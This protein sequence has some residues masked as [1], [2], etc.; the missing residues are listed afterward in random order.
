MQNVKNVKLKYCFILENFIIIPFHCK[1]AFKKRAAHAYTIAILVPLIIPQYAYLSSIKSSLDYN[2]IKL[3]SPV[4]N[5]LGE[6]TLAFSD[7][8][9]WDFIWD[10]IY[11]IFME[12]R[13]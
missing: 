8:C 11:Q 12:W 3:K 1:G 10:I 6:Y 13:N 9:A 5:S 7:N 2:N 4:L